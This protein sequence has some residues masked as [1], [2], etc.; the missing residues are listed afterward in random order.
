[1]RRTSRDEERGGHGPPPR[2]LPLSRRTS[3]D[4]ERGGQQSFQNMLQSAFAG[5]MSSVLS[6][7]MQ[8]EGQSASTSAGP[9]NR[10]DDVSL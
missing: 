3:R 4:E 9:S 10:R 8:P 5:A 7:G 2:D 6:Y 1:M